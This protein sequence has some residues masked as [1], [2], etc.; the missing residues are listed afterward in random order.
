MGLYDQCSLNC[1]EK[2]ELG[3]VFDTMNIRE[4]KRLSLCPSAKIS[5]LIKY[6]RQVWL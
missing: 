6:I 3:D 5:V 4:S 1:N 2:E